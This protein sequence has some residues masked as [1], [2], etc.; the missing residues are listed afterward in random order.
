[1]L[2]LKGLKT[3]R[4]ISSKETCSHCE[5]SQINK[6]FQSFLMKQFQSNTLIS[7]SQSAEHRRLEWKTAESKKG[8]SPLVHILLET[9]PGGEG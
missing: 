5:N 1:M 4:E 7:S 3:K 6:L 2:G 9:N 8:K